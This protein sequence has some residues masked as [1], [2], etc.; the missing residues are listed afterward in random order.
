[1]GSKTPFSINPEQPPRFRQGK[2]EG[3]ILLKFFS[4][5]LFLNSKFL[6]IN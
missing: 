3:L 1:M 2:V 4:Q 6:T 5:L